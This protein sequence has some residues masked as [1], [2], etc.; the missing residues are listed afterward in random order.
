MYHAVVAGEMYRIKPEV[1]E[2]IATMDKANET[3][4][5]LGS[6]GAFWMRETKDGK[7]ID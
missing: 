6:K 7:L 4:K 2:K 3:L 1:K 5:T